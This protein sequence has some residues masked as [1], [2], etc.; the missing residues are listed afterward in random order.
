MA[1]PKKGAV[2]WDANDSRSFDSGECVAAG[3]SFWEAIVV[4]LHVDEDEVKGRARL[5]LRR[6][7]RSLLFRLGTNIR[8]LILAAEETAKVDRKREATYDYG[9][10]K[11]FG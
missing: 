4:M 7:G 2:V 11:E 6:L 8:L 3:E 1:G 5:S 10:E 9:G